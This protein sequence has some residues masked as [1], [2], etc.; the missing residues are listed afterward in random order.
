VKYKALRSAAHNFGASFASGLNYAA[1]DY[2]MS[3]LAR[4]ALASG[5]TEM[6]VDLLT[7]EA[8]P[9][10]LMAPPVD[11]S[12]AVRLRWFPSLLVSQRIDPI[13]V[14]DARL[15]IDT[16]QCT[17]P[18]SVDGYAVR[19]MP[20]DCWVTLLDD[21]NKTH[22]AHFRRRWPFSVDGTEPGTPRTLSLWRKLLAAAR[23]RR[24]GSR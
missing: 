17:A 20:F 16:A 7:G 15:R 14:R 8:G 4:R 1:G 23:R 13:V 24:S 21:H 19:E 12:I 5:Q 6:T 2:I 3:H 9:P 11:E 22:A 10:A 18:V